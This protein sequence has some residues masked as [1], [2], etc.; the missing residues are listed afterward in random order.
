MAF[1]SMKNDQ[2]NPPEQTVR[3]SSPIDWIERLTILG[4]YGWLC[5]RIVVSFAAQ[6]GIVNLLLLT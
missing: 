3:K 6:G 2:G 1:A 4:L 5:A